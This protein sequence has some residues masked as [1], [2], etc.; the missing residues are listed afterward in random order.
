MGA[1][2]W[3]W[4]LSTRCRFDEEC[5]R[6]PRADEAAAEFAGIEEAQEFK[7]LDLTS[8]RALKRHN[9]FYKSKRRMK[10]AANVG[11]IIHEQGRL[12][13]GKIH[14]SCHACRPGEK[15]KYQEKHKVDYILEYKQ[16]AQD[17]HDHD[18]FDS[19]EQ[20]HELGRAYKLYEGL[21]K[22][23]EVVALIQKYK[24]N[25][26]FGEEFQHYFDLLMEG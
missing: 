13:K 8:T 26:W 18:V 21:T 17:E 14:C 3:C 6:C 10:I 20:E 15:P 1:V 22:A 23:H 25:D 5:D 4:A 7:R 11:Y 24:T 2:D 9:D 19:L 16:W 12:R